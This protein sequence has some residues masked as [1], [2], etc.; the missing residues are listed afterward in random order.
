MK[1]LLF[2]H[3]CL[4]TLA[5]AGCGSTASSNPSDYVGEYVFRPTN[6]DPGK[7]A[8]FLV[9]KANQEAIEIRF[10]RASGQLQTKQEKWYLS[11]STGQNVV[12]GGFSYSVEGSHSA[13][14]LGV[15]DDLGQYY[16]K[17]R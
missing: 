4:L 8:S 6:V 12:I 9:L 17:V 7:S 10:D 16:E 3:L 2:L 14:K 13:I 15:N 1:C 11:R 5:L